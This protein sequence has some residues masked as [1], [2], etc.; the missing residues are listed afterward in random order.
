MY[1]APRT[2][3][4]RRRSAP[5][6]AQTRTTA[7]SP[8]P[9][10]VQRDR[11]PCQASGVGHDRH[12]AETAIVLLL[13]G[14]VAIDRGERGAVEGRRGAVEHEPTSRETGDAVRELAGQADLVEAHED[15][16]AV[17]AA[18]PPD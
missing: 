15:R 12:E 9:N 8:H 3:S 13:V 18:H 2:T 14:P 10:G 11:A 17:L 4:W 1:G 16:E 6:A 7:T 5:C